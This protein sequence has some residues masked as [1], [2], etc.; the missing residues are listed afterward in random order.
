[1]Y[2]PTLFGLPQAQRG[3][4]K[5]AQTIAKRW[6]HQIN[7]VTS[8]SF[9]WFITTQTGVYRFHD[10]PETG[11]WVRWGPNLERS[12]L[13]PYVFSGQ[14]FDHFGD[15][16]YDEETRT[17][18]VAVEGGGAPAIF[19]FDSE[20]RYLRH[21]S[22]SQTFTP[23]C[24]AHGGLV[25]TSEFEADHVTGYDVSGPVARAVREIQLPHRIA[26]IQG[27]SFD[28]QGRLV[29][30]SDDDQ[31]PHLAVVNLDGSLHQ[32]LPIDRRAFGPADDLVNA[33]AGKPASR[34][35]EIQGLDAHGGALALLLSDKNWLGNDGLIFLHYSEVE[36]E[37]V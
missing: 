29:L 21:S 5:P 25:Y 15:C 11:E 19:A 24:A 28:K 16:D 1:M 34:D 18:W 23:W 17:L 30:A 10:S 4:Q 6:T 2:A 12:G 22:V 31:D 9:G 7:G 27:G 8:A 33:L 20:L 37:F 26:R 13:L 3:N 14:R 32:K 36:E 35:K